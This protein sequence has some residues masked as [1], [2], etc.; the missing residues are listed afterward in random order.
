MIS[1]DF[2]KVSREIDQIKQRDKDSQESGD[3]RA[4][5]QYDTVRGGK[6][7]LS[8]DQYGQLLLPSEGPQNVHSLPKKRRHKTGQVVP[9]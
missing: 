1:N 4:L 2:V 7:I 8:I 5:L 6:E 3:R 9:E